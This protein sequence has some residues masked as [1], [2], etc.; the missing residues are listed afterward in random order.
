MDE[1][2]TFGLAINRVLRQRVGAVNRGGQMLPI[3]RITHAFQSSASN[4]YLIDIL[5]NSAT[6]ASVT[7]CAPEVDQALSQLSTDTIHC[8]FATSPL[9]VFVPR[10]QPEYV[11]FFDVVED[12]RQVERKP[13][14]WMLAGEIVQGMKPAPLTINLAS[15]N[16]AQV[17]AAGTTGSGKTTLIRNLVLSLSMM[18][19]YRKLQIVALDPKMAALACLNGLP[20]LKHEV[21]KEPD[22]CM[23]ALGEAIAEIERRKHLG[24]LNP[25]E[26][27]IVAIDEV[28]ELIDTA[29]DEVTQRIKRIAQI[30]REFGVHLI[31]ATQKP[32]SSEVGSV[33]KANFPFRFAGRVASTDD[34]KV[35]L[36]RKGSQ[37]EQLAGKGAFVASTATGFLTLQVYNNEP[38]E[39]AAYVRRV[40]KKAVY[41]HGDTVYS[42]STWENVQT[43]PKPQWQTV[44]KP[45]ETDDNEGQTA[46]DKLPYRMPNRR[47]SVII[48]T[49]YKALEMNKNATIRHFWPNRNKVKAKEYVDAA[50]RTVNINREYINAATGEVVTA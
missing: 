36:G 12:L 29:G 5:E 49:I 22:D 27:Y 24:K 41:T 46:T 44:A 23:D 37:A 47:E 15:P 43:A 16:V 19:D 25:E 21:L 30:G 2:K 38:D 4:V 32:L 14:L 31:A 11:R 45:I 6:I 26:K 39:I 8:R 28:A 7:R 42:G 10:V 9:R 3:A 18:N 1:L 48:C 33:A 17:F 20:G 35:A 34:A 13:G 50:L 40:G